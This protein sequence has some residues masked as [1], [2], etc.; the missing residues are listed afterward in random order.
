[1]SNRE[2]RKLAA[3]MTLV[4]AQDSLKK[5]RLI[6][7]KQCLKKTSVDLENVEKAINKLLGDIG[8]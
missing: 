3:K 5:V 4:G 6:L 8:S 1:M 7:G 2:D